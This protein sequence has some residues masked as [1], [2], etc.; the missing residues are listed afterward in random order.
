MHMEKINEIQKPDKIEKLEISTSVHNMP[1][2]QVEN[3]SPRLRR[4]ILRAITANGWDDPAYHLHRKAGAFFQADEEDYLLV[5]FWKPDYQ[6]FVDY[7][8]KQISLENDK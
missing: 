4:I 7:L 2:V 6:P 1:C 5:E 3:P 8:N